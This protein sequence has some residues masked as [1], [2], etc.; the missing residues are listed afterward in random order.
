M[1]LQSDT[2]WKESWPGNTTPQAPDGAGNVARSLGGYSLTNAANA[3]RY[4]KFYDLGSAPVIGTTAPK[5][6]VEVPANGHVAVSFTRG[7]LFS[8][9]LWASVTVNAADSDN[10]AAGANDV[11][12]TVDYQ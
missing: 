6:T 5:R 3:A 1:P 4:V 7:I 12:V 11:L 10:T 2:Q 8:R 9:G